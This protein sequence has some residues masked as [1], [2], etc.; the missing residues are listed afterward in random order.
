[1]AHIRIKHDH[2]ELEIEG[3]YEFI[4]GQ[5]VQFYISIEEYEKLIRDLDCDET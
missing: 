5:L 2:H 4:Q 3:D 1:M